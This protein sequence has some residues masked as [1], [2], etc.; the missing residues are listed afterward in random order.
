M[1][2]PRRPYLFKFFKG[3]FPQILLEYSPFLNTLFH[4]SHMYVGVWSALRR[5]CQF[6]FFKDCLPQILLGP[7]LNALTHLFFNAVDLTGT[8]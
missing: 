7:F 4:M 1:I 3:C 8:I 6:K 5:P 2:Y